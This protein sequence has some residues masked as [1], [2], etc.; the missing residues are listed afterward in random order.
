MYLG[1]LKLNLKK[2]PTSKCKCIT[3]FFSF[4][5]RSEWKE[6][7][8]DMIDSVTLEK[9]VNC[10]IVRRRSRRPNVCA[11]WQ[12]IYFMCALLPQKKTKWSH[13]TNN[14]PLAFAN[15][16]FWRKEKKN[17]FFQTSSPRNNNWWPSVF[18]H[19]K[20]HRMPLV[21]HSFEQVK[22]INRKIE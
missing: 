16:N 12:W 9:S 1:S 8:W 15:P 4:R 21:I 5:N 6:R 22:K 3:K 7:V 11:V 17:N 2:K 19:V 10:T 13:S 14:F 20:I 18:L